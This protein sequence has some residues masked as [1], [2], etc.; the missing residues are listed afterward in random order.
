MDPRTTELIMFLGDEL[1]IT[2]PGG[3][4]QK[5][6]KCKLTGKKLCLRTKKKIQMLRDI[7]DGKQYTPVK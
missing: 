4:D 2:L 1:A 7:N 3:C 6:K 5:C